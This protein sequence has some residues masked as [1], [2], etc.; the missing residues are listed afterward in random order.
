[1]RL[2][3][4]YGYSV[5]AVIDRPRSHPDITIYRVNRTGE[6]CSPLQPDRQICANRQIPRR[7]GVTPPYG[8]TKQKMCPLA[9][10]HPKNHR[11]FAAFYVKAVLVFQYRQ[12]GGFGAVDLRP[13]V[14]LHDQ[15]H[16]RVQIGGA[17]LGFQ[18]HAAVPIVGDPAGQP[19]MQRGGAGV[20]A[21]P[22]P[23]HAAVKLPAAAG[24]RS[25]CAAS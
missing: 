7:G 8:A 14:A 10:T 25:A 11:L 15:R 13:A 1:M 19:Q 23:L 18:R 3:Q 24:V 21:K 17:S 9:R 22:Y 6:Q 2:Q 20:V 4:H 16:Q 5:G 12:I